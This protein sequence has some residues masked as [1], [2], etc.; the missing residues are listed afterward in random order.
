VNL[1]DARK[2]LL[3][4][5][6]FVAFGLAFAITASTYEVGSALRMG[7]GY[8]PLVLGS[9]LVLLGI[10]IGV[11]GFV[12]GEG[13]ELGPVP[14]RAVAL[15]VAALLFF[16][17]TVRGLGLVP[18]LFVTVFLSAMAGRRARVIPAVVIAACLTALSALIFVVGLQ[19]RL[20]YFGPWLG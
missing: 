17:Y 3:A 12:A 18:S 20:P 11:K 14:W 10:L 13:G 19:L 2:D 16:G 1:H 15:L 4:G 5:G 9:L 7:P 8:F 6:T